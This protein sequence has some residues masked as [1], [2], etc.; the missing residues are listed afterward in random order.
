VGIE[1]LKLKLQAPLDHKHLMCVGWNGIYANRAFNCWVRNVE[2]ESAENPIILASAKNIT[3]DNINIS[4]PGQNHHSIGIRVNS[5]DNLIQNFVVDGPKRVKHGINIEWLSSG[6]VYSKGRM[7]KGT[8]DSHRALSFDL[9]RTEIT[10]ANDADGP[11]G[12]GQA[13][14][15]LGARVVH[16]NIDIKN[17]PRKD[18]GEFVNM[19]EA[20]PMGLLVGIRGAGISA[21]PAPGMPKGEKGTIIADEGKIPTP[22]N[23][24]EAQRKLRLGK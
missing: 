12:A 17:S 10:L 2:I 15:F 21:G 20:L 6:N 8:F 18:P 11:G 4:G 14:P 13:G 24:Y 3:A 23:L 19:P 5:H 22:P 9:I 7:M 16:W 1:N